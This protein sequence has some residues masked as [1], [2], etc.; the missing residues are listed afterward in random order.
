MAPHYDI[1]GTCPSNDSDLH[2]LPVITE[3]MKEENGKREEQHEARWKVTDHRIRD[4]ANNRQVIPEADITR[5]LYS[6]VLQT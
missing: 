2:N 3:I 4:N 1:A 5:T 6:K